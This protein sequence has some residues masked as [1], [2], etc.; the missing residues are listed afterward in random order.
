MK[1]TMKF[2]ASGTGRIIRIVVGAALVIWGIFINPTWLGIIV[3]VIGLVPLLAG[4]FDKCVF[5][6]LFGLPFDGKKLRAS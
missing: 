5:A 1:G 2:L 6:P 4:I 3:V